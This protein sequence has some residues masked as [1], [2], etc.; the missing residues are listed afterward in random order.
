MRNFHSIMNLASVAQKRHCVFQGWVQPLI[1]LCCF[2]LRI[3][4]SAQIN[5]AA[6]ADVTA[7]VRRFVKAQQSFD[8]SVLTDA[9]TEDYLEISPRGEVDK[10]N[11]V[12]RFYDPAHRVDVPSATISDEN[13]R[14]LGD[15]AVDIV[16]IKYMVAEEGK[17]SHD[18]RIRAAFVAIRRQGVWKLASAHY[19]TIQPTETPH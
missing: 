2:L 1:F 10:R 17:P 12:L 14:I 15:A 19:T 3:P 7:L 6:S 11:D 18:I 9:T 4:L 13:I 16:A 5:G 8:P